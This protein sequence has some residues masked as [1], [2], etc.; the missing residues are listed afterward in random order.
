MSSKMWQKQAKSNFL[1][2]TVLNTGLEF[3]FRSQE[4][5]NDSNNDFCVL[6]CV[7]ISSAAWLVCRYSVLRADQWEKSERNGYR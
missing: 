1:Y 7:G 4:E 3:S 2:S 6:I 5:A